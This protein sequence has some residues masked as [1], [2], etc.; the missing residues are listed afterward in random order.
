MAKDFGPRRHHPV[1][2]YLLGLGVTI[3]AAIIVVVLVAAVAI[4]DHKLTTDRQQSA[5]APFYLAPA[6]WQTKAPGTLLRQQP[7]SGVPSGGKGWRVLYVTETAN[8][9]KAVSSGLVFAPG[10]AAPPAP[11][12]GRPVVAWAHGTIGM[13]DSCAPSRTPNVESDIQGLSN[14][15]NA[16]WVVTATDYA[17]LGTRGTE[18]Y[19]IGQAEAHDVLNSV[20]AARQMSGVNASTKVSVWGHSQGGQAALWTAALRD[21]APELNVVAAAAAAPAAELPVLI[22]HQWNSLAGSLIASEVLVAFPVAYPGLSVAEVSSW[23]PGNIADAANKCIQTGL[24]DLAVGHF[25]GER[26][27]LSKNPLT[28]SSWA[29]A[30]AKSIP[31]YPTIPTYLSQGTADPLVLPGSNAQF[32]SHACASGSPLDAL[33]IGDLGHM[34]AGSASAPSVFTWL[35]QRFA[36]V[37]LQSTCGTLLPVAPLTN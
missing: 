24:I 15:L 37:P 35:Q 5:L 4:T 11:A 10:S 20:R 8:G 17:G 26:T 13:G 23:S 9:T 32:V 1:T 34:K 7:V 14:F 30:L 27:L 19:L 29:A 33:F 3:L 28:V 2:G 21:Y 6:G 31:P 36:G 12:S 25:F 18:E 22:N 16:G